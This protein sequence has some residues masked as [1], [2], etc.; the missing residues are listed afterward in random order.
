MRQVLYILL[1]FA[2]IAF[3]T[4]AY[5][6]ELT[7]IAREGREK[8]SA[9]VE[10]VQLNG[11][12]ALA[13]VFEGTKD[14]HYYA[15]AQTA[16]AEGLELN[17]TAKAD[18]L[19]FGRAIFP[20]PGNFYDPGQE[21]DVEVYVGAFEVY[22]PI[23]NPPAGG[24]VQ[25]QAI[26]AGIACTS[27][28]CLAPFEKTVP[29]Q[30]DFTQAGTWRAVTSDL[31]GQRAAP[32]PAPTAGTAP[33]A[34]V[35]ISQPSESLG[36]LLTG[37]QESSNTQSASGQVV[38]YFLLALLAG[39]SINIM[40]CVLPVI[41]LIVMR[42]VSQTKEAPS[43]RIGLGLSFCGGIV[44]F[45]AAFAALSAI[46]KIATGSSLDLNS[47]Y[48]N[49]TAV[50]VLFLLIVLF[51]LA[52]MD[53]L[54]LS[55]PSSLAGKQGGGA[56]YA[57]SVAMGF[58]AGILSTPCS[59]AII[60]AVLVWAQTQPTAV[61][62]T[63]LIL[64]GV[65]MA[66]PYAVLVSVPKLLSFVPRPGTWMEHFK[67]AGGFLLLLI[68]VKF[69]LTGLTKDHLINVLLYGVVFAFCVW[70]WGSWVNFATPAGRKWATRA[71]ALAIAV[72]VG[73]WLLPVPQEPVMRWQAYNAAAIQKAIENRQPVLIKFTADW[74]TNCKVLEK[75]VYMD[76]QV[77]KLVA[78]KKIL[79][80]KADT[81]QAHYPAAVDL[82]SVF[83]EAGNV[84]V[85][86]LLDPD[87]KSITKL[88]GI[89]DKQELINKL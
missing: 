8:S 40:P 80:V 27:K 87:A 42:L 81:T 21:K 9:R 57:G 10:P 66:V 73:F 11:S 62:V 56:G 89:F 64:M 20:K 38:W 47:L 31:A 14:L 39:L 44:L 12:P 71:A 26:V 84:P 29:A 77:A 34:E 1:G 18:G 41:P 37:W 79:A 35:V 53:V 43:R 65:G 72:A 24:T 45:F 52:L 67:K 15:S 36:Q 33:T 60:G 25:A 13:V 4:T 22:I 74:C 6:T 3:S 59:G 46:I 17:I 82:K 51:A 76:P 50:I 85:T 88:R 58:F 86:I 28:V 61:S 5:A 69:T 30:I 70:M 75:T 23:I 7:E 49:P 63:A 32:T 16:P 54:T 83:G 78:D 2:A 48:R 55:L 19:S 68:A